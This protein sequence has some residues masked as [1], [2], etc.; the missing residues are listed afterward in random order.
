MSGQDAAR[1][2]IT[3]LCISRQDP[4]RKWRLRILLYPAPVVGKGE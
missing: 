1:E 4:P 2:M 3:W